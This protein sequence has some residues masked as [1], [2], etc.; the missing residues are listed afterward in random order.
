[1][2]S[3]MMQR[4]PTSEKLFCQMTLVV[5]CGDQAS[6]VERRDLIQCAEVIDSK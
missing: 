1:M 2:S 3:S 5:T 6:T 4:L